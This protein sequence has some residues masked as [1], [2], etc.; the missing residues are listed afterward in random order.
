M[1]HQV[2]PG[3]S[4]VFNGCAFTADG[5]RLFAAEYCTLNSLDNIFLKVRSWIN[6]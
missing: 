6:D 1:Y 4:H 3:E 2:K 5:T